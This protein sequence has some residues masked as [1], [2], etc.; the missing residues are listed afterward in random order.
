MAVHLG[1]VCRPVAAEPQ[2]LALR[3]HLPHEVA[4]RLERQPVVCGDTS[5]CYVVVSS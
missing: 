1:L 3:T 4:E 2:V 5:A